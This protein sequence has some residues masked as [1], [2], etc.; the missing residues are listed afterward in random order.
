MYIRKHWVWIS[1]ETAG[2]FIVFAFPLLVMFLIL[3]AFG[4]PVINIF[5]ISLYSISNILIFMWSI[6]SWIYLAEKYTKYALNFWILTNK[7]IIESELLKLFDRRLSTLGLEEIEDVTVEVSA[8]FENLIGWGTLEVQTA[9]TSREF[10][11]KDI[12]SPIKVQRAI[13]DVKLALKQ[14][15]K[16]IERGEVEQ[17]THRVMM[18]NSIFPKEQNYADMK[19]EEKTLL[20]EHDFDWAK[21]A[22]KA[23]RSE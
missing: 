15:E 9:G 21:D 5:G 10:L 1:L 17:I 23:L 13:F 2:V 6:L 20:K 18:E 3:Y 11:A 16:D 14:N 12:L 7:R 8:V 19:P 22:D 4:F